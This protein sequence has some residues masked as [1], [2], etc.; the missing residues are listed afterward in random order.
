MSIPVHLSE[1]AQGVTSVALNFTL[2]VATA[3]VLDVTSDLPEG[4]IS[5]HNVGGNTL[6]IGMAGGS[7]ISAGQIATIKL[8]LSGSDESLP[9]GEFRL[10][11]S[12]A[13]AVQAQAVPSEFALMGN[14]PNPFSGS[15]TIG[16][17][18][19]S[20][21]EVTI[22]VYDML[23]REVA[24]LVNEQKA[25]GQYEV[26]WDGRGNSGS[27]VSSGVYFYRIKAGDFTASNKMVVVR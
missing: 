17:E 15:T 12:E 27:S 4:W 10:N 7:A 3:N 22:K 26:T 24:T 21:S 8:E 25:A 11:G 18:L 20:S 2:D 1:G 23:G 16:Y 9:E 13:Q 5:G 6:K 19:S 14:Y